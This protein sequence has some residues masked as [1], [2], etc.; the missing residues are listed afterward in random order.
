MTLDFVNDPAHPTFK[1]RERSIAFLHE[2][3]G[4]PAPQG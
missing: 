3:L 1:A 4:V 2:R